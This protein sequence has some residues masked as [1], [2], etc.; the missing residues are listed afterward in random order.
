[1]SLKTADEIMV[2]CRTGE[3]VIMGIVNVTP[4]SFSDGGN[5]YAAELA[6]KHGIRL[7]DEGAQILDIGGESTRPGADNVSIEEEIERVVPV[8]SALSEQGAP[9]ISIDTRNAATM[10]AAIDAGANFI[11][12]I[13]GLFHDEQSAVIVAQSGLPVCIMHMQGTPQTMQNHPHYE[14]VVDEV[15]AFFEERLTFCEEQ[16]ISSNKIILDP[17]IGFGKSVGHNLALIKDLKEFHRFGCPLLLGASRKSYIGAISG[18]DEPKNRLAGSL[19]TAIYE[20]DA[21]AQIFRVHDVKE[22]C[23]AFDVYNAIKKAD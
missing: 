15:C 14:N 19:S 21:G 12:D 7:L 5:Y 20:L 17:G 22:T 23:Q 6:I 3:P 11:N 9:V 2:L 4:D 16:G 8:I 13:S 18:E 10:R 1:M